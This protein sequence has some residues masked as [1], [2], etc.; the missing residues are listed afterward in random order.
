MIKLNEHRIP[1]GS[2]KHIKNNINNF[3][4]VKYTLLDGVHQNF[5]YM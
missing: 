5:T 1:Q 3:N 4:N 2:E